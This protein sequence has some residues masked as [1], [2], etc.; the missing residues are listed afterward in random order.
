MEQLAAD[1]HVCVYFCVFACVLYVCVLHVCVCMCVC[2]CVRACVCVREC[3][4]TEEE[5]YQMKITGSWEL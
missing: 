1:D 2:A 5:E 4:Y 3:I